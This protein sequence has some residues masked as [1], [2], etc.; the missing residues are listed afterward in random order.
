MEQMNSD[1]KRLIY[2]FGYPEHR[3]Y[4]KEIVEYFKHQA[5]KR[6]HNLKC[7]RRDFQVNIHVSP[8]PLRQ[9]LPELFNI[10]QHEILLNQMIDCRCCTNHSHSKPVRGGDGYYTSEAPK[11]QKEDCSCGCRNMARILLYS[12]INQECAPHGYEIQNALFICPT[13]ALY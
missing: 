9:L 2:S 8:C 13:Q 7:I 1:L 11:T 10:T 3:V 4:M 5:F 6:E 12:M